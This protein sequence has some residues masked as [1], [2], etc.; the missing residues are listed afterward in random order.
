VG[1]NSGA[2]ISI[3]DAN[4]DGAVNFLDL[5]IWRQQFAG[6]PFASMPAAAA[7]PEPESLVMMAVDAIG[8]GQIGVRNVGRRS[9]GDH[10]LSS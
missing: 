10:I 5:A 4:R 3:G 7:A 8:V 1:I 2:S 6:P 9:H